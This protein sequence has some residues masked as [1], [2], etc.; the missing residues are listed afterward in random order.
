MKKI[1]FDT[2]VNYI[3]RNDIYAFQMDDVVGYITT[4]P[5]GEFIGLYDNQFSKS[6]M[7]RFEKKNNEIIK[8]SRSLV[9]LVDND[10][11]ETQ[12]SM[13][14]EVPFEDEL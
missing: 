9:F 6:T 11:N 2:L 10:N 12:I 4:P 7:V 14:K 8:V 3:K 1:S 5:R 13:L